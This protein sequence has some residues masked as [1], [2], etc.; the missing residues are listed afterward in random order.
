[1]TIAP[2]LRAP[3]PSCSI[4][5]DRHTHKNGGS[6]MRDLF[7]RNELLD[8]WMYWGYGLAHVE[9]VVDGLL[10]LLL[11]SSNRSCTDWAGRPAL[12]LAAE[13]HYSY[14][15]A[16]V[17]LATFG[18]F[19]PL[20]QLGAHCGCRLVLVTRLRELLDFYLSFYRWTV[21]WR[22]AANASHW[23]GSMLE[24]RAR[25]LTHSR[26][27]ARYPDRTSH[28]AACTRH[29]PR[30]PRRAD[31]SERRACGGAVGASQPADLHPAHAVPRH[32]RRAR[33]RARAARH[34]RRP[35]Q[36]RDL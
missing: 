13:L 6:T 36:A 5:V 34:A 20:R 10:Q 7:M 4:V 33:G 17:L 22:Q 9:R 27:T 3:L 26:R 8:G 24:V 18:P 28:R 11:G 16:E 30:W 12:R 1:M 32:L 23:G 2:Y 15:T 31:A 14:M 35:R 21:A 29:R 19:S 25:R